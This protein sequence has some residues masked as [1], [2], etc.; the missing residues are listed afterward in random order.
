MYTTKK[1]FFAG[2]AGAAGL[3]L[4]GAMAP[5]AAK[6][7]YT[8]PVTVYNTNSQPVEGADV[9]KQARI[10]Y[11]SSVAASN[12]TSNNGPGVC[13]FSFAPPPA[14]Y[15]IVVENIAGY[16]QI[17][18]GTTLPVVGYIEDGNPSFR[19]YTAF[20]APVG[21]LDAGGHTQAAFN[22]PAK[23]HLDTGDSIF[24][25]VSTNWSNGS[26]T[27]ALEGYLESCAI[28]GC[29]AVQH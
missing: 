7:I 24:A 29:P 17:S 15:R 21:S 4:I 19:I 13:F 10:P 16:F 2:L 25:V 14:G 1:K 5:R 22:N 28:T 27:M 9:E 20:T 26:S 6:A 8:T 11:V 23:F 3:L 18:P 12:C